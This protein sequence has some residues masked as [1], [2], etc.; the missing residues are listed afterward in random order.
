VEDGIAPQNLIRASGDPDSLKKTYENKPKIF[1]PGRILL[2]IYSNSCILELAAL[3]S[4]KKN[5][6][7]RQFRDKTLD[8]EKQRLINL[9]L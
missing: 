8:I 7:F 3:G 4:A 2:S 1:T 5:L 9:D 6:R